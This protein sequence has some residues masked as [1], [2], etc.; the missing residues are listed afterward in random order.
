MELQNL[1]N[2]QIA[3]F[4]L[5]Y[6]KLHRFHWYIEG[7]EFY[8][9]HTVF[10]TLYEEQTT[11]LDE[12]AERLLAI[13]GK[14]ASTMAEYLKL[15]SLSEDGTEK[16]TKEIMNALIND[17]TKI[18]SELKEGISIAEKEEDHITTDLLI[19]TKEILEKHVWMFKQTA[20]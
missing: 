7:A 6:F 15:S 4:A 11:F 1:L 16:K 10:Q 13:D 14:P 18:A 17:F 12:F 3:N 2:K 19:R 5:T 20:K 8:Q 9:L